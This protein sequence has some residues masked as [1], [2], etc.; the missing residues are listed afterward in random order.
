MAKQTEKMIP[1]SQ[2]DFQY[3]AEK[4]RDVGQPHALR[5][6]LVH[7]LFEQ[8]R[9]YEQGSELTV[10]DVWSLAECIADTVGRQYIMIERNP[11]RPKRRGR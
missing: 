9:N 7:Y 10:S 8:L 5:S 3:A 1:E 4:F 2:I 11:I 6:E